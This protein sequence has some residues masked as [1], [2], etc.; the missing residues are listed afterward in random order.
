MKTKFCWSAIKVVFEQHY[1]STR[2]LA[3]DL[4]VDREGFKK[5]IRDEN[6]KPGKMMTLAE[7]YRIIPK[8]QEA[9]QY[10]RAYEMSVV[11]ERRAHEYELACRILRHMI[12]EAREA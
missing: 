6:W 2:T 12:R 7:V 11:A 8:L 10:D 9:G 1:V 3:V 4:G 5:R